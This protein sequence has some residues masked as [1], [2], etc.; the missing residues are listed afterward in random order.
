M[1]ILS[2]FISAFLLISVFYTVASTISFRNAILLLLGYGLGFA[3]VYG[4]I[5]FTGAWKKCITRNDMQPIY[6]QLLLIALA[7]LVCVP[8][9]YNVEYAVGNV[10]PIGITVIVGA[11]IFGIGMQLS[12]SCG[13]GTLVAAASGSVPSLAT[14]IF[15]IIGSLIGS[16]ILPNVIQLN[17]LPIS[18]L[19][20]QGLFPALFIQIGGLAIIG[21]FVYFFTRQP[22]KLPQKKTFFALILVAIFM[23][24]TLF[25]AGRMWSITFGYTLWGAKLFQAVGGN[26]ESFQF[27]QWDFPQYALHT[28]ILADTT[29]VMN[30]GIIL[31]VG[32]FAYHKGNFSLPWKLPA[33]VF[34]ASVIGGL[35]MGIGARI[36]FGCNIGAYLSGIASASLHSWLWFVCAF[37]GSIIGIK[38]APIFMPRTS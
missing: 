34:W 4:K 1:K 19:K 22:F 28:S 7:C 24:L 25:L 9:L 3:F 6:E 5:S 12:G 2:Y 31:M 35:L 29:S 23:G 21:C 30:I 15:F 33:Q 27:W 32:V 13:S 18:L 11:F 8:I 10:A 20:T 16:F 38:L 36:S 14:L 26:V 17:G 37:V